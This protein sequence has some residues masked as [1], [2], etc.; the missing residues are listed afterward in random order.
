MSKALQNHGKDSK[1]EICRW[2]DNPNVKA[3]P[4]VLKDASVIPTPANPV[5]FHL[6]GH[7]SIP[8]S[9]V[10][11]EDDYF[12]FLVA[13]STK[14][15]LLPHQVKR[16]LAGT[17]LIFVGYRLADWDF[18][19]L[20]RGIVMAG[21]PA[22]RRLSITVQLPANEDAQAY[23]DNYFNRMQVGVFWGT[24]EQFMGELWE[25]WEAFTV[26]K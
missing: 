6:H 15:R 21:D 25:R 11:T 16:A 26:A 9:L 17:S 19:V 12:A 18:R 13:I 2:N 20:H 1:L 22:L 8:E 10:L 5:V 14:K 23:L 3:F 24:A 7:C 4:S